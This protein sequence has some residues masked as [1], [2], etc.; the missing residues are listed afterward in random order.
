MPE[1]IAMVAPFLSV[2]S[3]IAGIAQGA[4]A[5]SQQKKAGAQAS[6]NAAK[7]AQQ[8]EEQINRA[9]AKSPNGSAINQSNM[10]DS[11]G[12]G[13]GTMLTGSQGVDPSSLTL[14]K[15]TLLGQ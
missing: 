15:S 5:A 11:K 9:N 13:S 14:G 6:A 3:G 8:S 4:S 10:I 2:A 7:S 1:T 12:G